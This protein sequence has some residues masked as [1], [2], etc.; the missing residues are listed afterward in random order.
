MLISLNWI[1]E[2]LEIENINLNELIEK[3]TLGGFEVEDNFEL[4]IGNKKE[5]ILEISATANRAD[6]ISAKGIAKE[7]GS[8]I[9]KK[10]FQN[11]YIKNT[12]ELEDIFQKSLS[13]NEILNKQYCSSFIAITVE[14][15][16]NIKSPKWLKQK[17]ISSG[18]EPTDG[19][20][21]FQNYILL[22]TGYPFEFYDLDKIRKDLNGSELK[23]TLTQADENKSI[24]G[25][26]NLEY[27]LEVDTLIVKSNELL[28]SIAG[29]MPNEKYAPSQT[30]KA[31]LIEGSIFN[32]KKIRQTS[33]KLGLRTD[34][35]ARYEKSLN[36]HSFNESL[37]RLLNLLRI[38]NSQIIYKTTSIAQIANDPIKSIPLI[39]QNVLEILGPTIEDGKQTQITK[40]QISS[41][42]ERLDFNFN[43]E[44]TISKWNV[45]VPS[46]RIDDIT[47]EI[48]LIEEIGRLHG[49]NNFVSYL[50]SIPKVGI[51]DFSYQTRK[52]LTTCFLSEGLNELMQYS[53]VKEPEDKSQRI[54]L[55]NPL[56]SDCSTLRTS[57]LPAIMETISKNSKQ[58]NRNI[59]GFEFGHVFLST[60][61]NVYNEKEYVGGNFGSFQTKTTWSENSKNLSW[62]EAKGKLEDIFKKLN[63]GIYWKK[64]I[65]QT[66]ENMLHPYRTAQFN[67]LSGQF[68]GVFGQIHPVLAKTLNISAETYLFE[69]DFEMLKNQLKNNLLPLYKRY[70]LYPKIVKDL[71]FIVDQKYSFK[72]IEKSIVKTGTDVLIQLEL[73]DE[74]K[75]ESIPTNCTSLCIQLTFQSKEQTLRTEDIETIIDS[76][77]SALV[78]EYK[79]IQRV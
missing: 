57:L 10:A 76:I 66:Y 1:N 31:L 41:Y 79:I 53:L 23:L 11:T 63:I 48:D 50:P 29:I 15:L 37:V 27:N 12:S 3:L 18:L 24:V 72:E 65:P 28:L 16:N 7:I 30:T 33:R 17:L 51:E 55:V 58:G 13:N 67:L 49:F 43:F 40:E 74:Y 77:Q 61:P 35:S 78:Q 42:L 68:F 4:L 38:N 14:N 20:I 8:L 19:L 39:Y 34:R 21:D 69:F 25:T 45:I 32:S 26:N 59:E 73:L 2:L 5:T 9:N 6:S 44:S 36:N 70:S 47:R 56:I 52:K 62:F 22:E 71:S 46:S 54:K 64:T 60:S 75:G